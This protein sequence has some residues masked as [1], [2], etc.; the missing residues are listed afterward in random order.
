MSKYTRAKPA[1]RR[2]RSA[3]PPALSARQQGFDAIIYDTA[4]R[5]A[6]DDELMQ[7]LAEIARARGARQCAAG[8]RRAD[9][10]R[11]GERRA[12][13]RV[14]KRPRRPDPHQARRRR[15][16]RRGAR[17]EGRHRRPDQVPRHRR[18][19]RPHRDLPARRAWPRASSAWATSSAWS[20]TSSRSSTSAR[21][22][23]GASA[24][25]IL[26]GNFGMDDLLKQLRMIQRLGPLRDV[27]AKMPGFG[28]GCGTRRRGR[29]R[30][31]TGDDPVDDARRAAR[32]GAHRPQPRLAHR[33][34]SG[35]QQSEVVDLVKRFR[36]MR[37]LMAALGQQ[38]GLLSRRS[39]ARRGGGGL[40]VG[41]DFRA[42]GPAGPEPEPAQ[43][44]SI[45]RCSRARRAAGKTTQ[46]AS[47]KGVARG[48]E[49]A[50]G[51]EQARKKG[52]KR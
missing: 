41:A 42:G 13:L 11:R 39:S 14:A 23:G 45:R 12:G 9:G 1:N 50:Q 48:Q 44:A 5:L 6:I 30:Q 36:Q 33:A 40:L 32:P 46:P 51:R 43:A 52:R 38:G 16:R 35:R 10:P 22:R 25:R 24:E 28:Q 4:G 20:R 2:R 47:P 18:G 29:A 31:G 26:R 3:R 34:G 7:E 27:M 17:G 15:A 49:E 19:R 8:L 21:P 37:D